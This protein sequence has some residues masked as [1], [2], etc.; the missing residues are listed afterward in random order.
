MDPLAINAQHVHNKIRRAFGAVDG[1]MLPI[2]REV[3]IVVRMCVSRKE[4]LDRELCRQ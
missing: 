1:P 3:R 4:R 2:G